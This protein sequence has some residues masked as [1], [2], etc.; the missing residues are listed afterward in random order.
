MEK[1]RSIIK[2][3]SQSDID[4][5]ILKIN[6]YYSSNI[7][8][9]EHI[10][11]TQLNCIG[12][13]LLL[14]PF[15]EGV[16]K[17]YPS[18]IITIVCYS[19]VKDVFSLIEDINVI[20]IDVIDF[21][22]FLNDRLYISYDAESLLKLTY[23]AEK[24]LKYGNVTK[25]LYPRLINESSWDFEMI[26]NCLAGSKERIGLSLDS[27]SNIFFN[28]LIKID[29][30]IIHTLDRQNYLLQYLGLSSLQFNLKP[31]KRI[32]SDNYIC[33][34]LGGSFLNKKYPV[35]KYA[36]ALNEINK[37]VV[38]IGGTN[39][40]KDANKL[41]SLLTCSYDNYVNKLSLLD[42]IALVSNASFYIGNDTWCVHVASFKNIP[43]IVLYKESIKQENI[44][45]EHLSMMRIFESKSTKHINLRPEKALSPC[46]K[47]TNEVG[48]CSAKYAHCI[49]QIKPEEIIKAYYSLEE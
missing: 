42:S 11:I 30:N 23:I 37:H 19:H 49:N 35:R 15:I 40:E 7:Y 6:D 28:N 44:D 10:L 29:K 33:I 24:V 41:C 8:N 16:K 47:I 5:I 45:P 27:K 4:D 2:D 39:E 9:K 36:K 46:N 25:S 3:N 21:A 38:L 26:I 12:D 17:L 31:L 43:S 14:L 22:S 13:A 1:I 32:I 48:Y 18:A 20:D 34:G